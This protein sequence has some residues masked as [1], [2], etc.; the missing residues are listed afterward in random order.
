MKAFGQA[1]LGVFPS[2][3][4]VAGEIE[5]SGG[6]RPIG[7]VTGV[8]EHYVAISPERRLRH[9]AVQRVTDTARRI[10]GSEASGKGGGAGKS[11][12]QVVQALVHREDAPDTEIS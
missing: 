8:D 1:G 9:P 3:V 6:A 4:V 12:A 2:P 11:G 5:R 10:F 7:T